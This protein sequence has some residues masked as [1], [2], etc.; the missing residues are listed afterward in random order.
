MIAGR[1]G[2]WEFSWK[3]A[4]H[5][6]SGIAQVEVRE[7]G[8]KSAG[9]LFEVR[10]RRDVDGLWLELPGGVHG[11]DVQGEAGDDGRPMFQVSERGGE[12]F[13]QCL[14]YLRSGE[15]QAAAG[16]AGAKKN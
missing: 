7:A 9:Q 16:A 10:W 5:G 4:P 3:S 14:S 1:V 15:E 6:P 11:F 12:R 13:W 2:K 8:A